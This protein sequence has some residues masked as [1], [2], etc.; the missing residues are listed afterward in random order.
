MLAVALPLLLPLPLPLL[1]TMPMPSSPPRVPERNSVPHEIA[2]G[3]PTP[4][5]GEGEGAGQLTHP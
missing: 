3:I 2:R 1:L 4:G 5:E